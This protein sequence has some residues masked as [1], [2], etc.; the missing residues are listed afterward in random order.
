MTLPGRGLWPLAEATLDNV[1]RH[2]AAGRTGPF[3]RGDEATIERDAEA[4]PEAWRDLFV[5]LGRSLD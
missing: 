3:V 5:T 1:R 2:G 4:L